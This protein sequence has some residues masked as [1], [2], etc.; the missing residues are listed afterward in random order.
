MHTNRPTTIIPD[1][2]TTYPLAESDCNVSEPID[3]E[4][5]AQ[6]RR[7]CDSPGVAFSDEVLDLFTDELDRRVSAIRD[8][9]NCGDGAALA[10]AAHV[11]KGS[12]SMVGALPMAELCLQLELAGKSDAT[13]AARPLLVPLEKEVLRVRCAL[14][15]ARSAG[16][17]QSSRSEDGL[18][19]RPSCRRSQ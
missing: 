18:N 16:G 19:D 8:A 2:S 1:D 14:L 17:G 9:M 13:A 7:E 10:R 4:T 6:L 3:A 12:S 5:L 15:A 11:L